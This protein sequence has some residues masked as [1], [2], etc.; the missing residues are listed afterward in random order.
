[1]IDAMKT[2][3]LEKLIGL[4]ENSPDYSS[5]T[6]GDMSTYD[7][8]LEAAISTVTDGFFGGRQAIAAIPPGWYPS[9]PA[10]LPVARL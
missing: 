9:L 6:F 10:A 7:Q 2:S 3:N 4:M 8:F 5:I 1:M